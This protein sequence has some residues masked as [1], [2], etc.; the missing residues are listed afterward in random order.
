VS[1]EVVS[2]RQ[3]TLKKALSQRGL[4]N[5]RQREILTEI[6]FGS[7]RHFSLEALLELA[8]ERDPGIGYATVYRTLKLLTEIG[9]AHERRFGQG[10]ARYEASDGHHHDHLICVRCNTIV[11]FEEPRIETL[12]LAVA[13]THGFQL[14]HHR[15]ELYGVCPS[16]QS[17]DSDTP[18]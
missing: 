9:L 11:E 12:Q 6:F 7:D 13:T 8:R 16:C 10:S 2:R 4:R 15:M 1:P 18:A 3:A 17:E 5:T 14:T